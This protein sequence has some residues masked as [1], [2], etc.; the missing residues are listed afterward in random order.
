MDCNPAT[1]IYC[2]LSSTEYSQFLTEK[3]NLVNCTSEQLGHNLP[4]DK[5]GRCWLDEEGQT[6]SCIGG[7]TPEKYS[8]ETTE[9][10][11]YEYVISLLSIG[12]GGRRGGPSRITCP[13]SEASTCNCNRNCGF[14]AD[15][16]EL[17]IC[18]VEQ[19]LCLDGCAFS[20]GQC[21]TADSEENGCISG[22]YRTDI[23]DGEWSCLGT[24]GGTDKSCP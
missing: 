16:S 12:G 8:C 5:Y 18:R 1:A 6:T 11:T 19:E 3:D 4:A 20:N 13:Y 17:N 24:G 23:V 22:Y 7:I 14:Y 2:G 15:L 10:T 9:G 21:G